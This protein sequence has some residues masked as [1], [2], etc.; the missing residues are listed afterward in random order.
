MSCPWYPPRVDMKHSRE[1][2]RCCAEWGSN[3]A[4][5]LGV[6]VLGLSAILPSV[7]AVAA[8]PDRPAPT[9]VHGIIVDGISSGP[10]SAEKLASIGVG[11]SG[12]RQVSTVAPAALPSSA[13]L[14]V[15]VQKQSKDYYCAPASGR[16][17]LSAFIVA[18]DLPSQDAI[19]RRM[20]TTSQGTAT[21]NVAVGLNASQSKNS[22]V[23]SVGMDLATYR[24]VVQ[25]G[26]STYKAP[27]VDAVEMARLPW[28][29][30][31]GTSG[32]HAVATYGY[33]IATK[34][35]QMHVFDPWDAVRH[36][37]V[38]STSMYNASLD[39]GITW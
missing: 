8:S 19:A 17:A 13:T 10:G 16:V 14:A 3:G 28:Y 2:S 4:T 39:Q 34:V 7:T 9:V 26:I 11:K 1:R 21:S 22:Y 35:W 18:K 24:T 12:V 32:G 30:G 37:Y 15:T 29:A 27:Q 20:G 23:Y 33:Y 6:S 25:S 5:S 31:T 38:N 36:T